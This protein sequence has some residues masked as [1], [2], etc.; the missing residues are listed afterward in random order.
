MTEASLFDQRRAELGEGA[1]WHPERQQLFWFDILS[2]RMFARDGARELSWELG[3]L[4]SAAGWI[5]QDTL[6]V[7]TETGLWRLALGDGSRTPI[8][9]IAADDPTTRS[10]DG[11][12]D[13]WGGFWA[14]T[15]GLAGEPGKGEIW[16]W[17]RGQLRRLVSGLTVPNAICFEG[18]HAF[19][20]DTPSG[21]IHRLSLDAEGWPLGPAEVFLDLTEAGLFPDGAVTD[22]AGQI[23]N[24]QWGA[25]RVAHY[26]AQGR[27]LG[28]V[29]TPGARLS[30]CPCFGGPDL[31]DLYITTAQEGMSLEDRDAEPDA[32]KLFVARGAGQGRPS[33][34]IGL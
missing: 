7:S 15:I 26:D 18:L 13:P 28:A 29:T 1:F 19:F 11:R 10:N 33:P 24:A 30:S 14:S 23:W 32:G 34:R 2:R 22:A 4:A 20:T 27:F 6:L 9:A 25:G 17:H 21:V 3:E 16:R 5:D 8:A 31:R 12:T